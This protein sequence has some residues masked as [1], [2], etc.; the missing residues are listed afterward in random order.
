MSSTVLVTGASGRIGRAL[1]GRLRCESFVSPV[2]IVSPRT[3]PTSD[4]ISVDLRDSRAVE[5]TIRDV[6]PNLVVH[7]AAVVPTQRPSTRVG[8]GVDAISQFSSIAADAGARRVVFAS[9]AAVYGDRYAAPI[10]EDAEVDPRS[11]YA[12]AKLDEEAMLRALEIESVSLRIFNVY[13]AGFDDSLV[14]RLREAR[15]EEPV[16]LFGTGEFVRDYV[17]VS[18]VVDAIVECLT[19]PL[20]EAHTVINVGSGVPTSTR[21]LI[22]CL[23]TAHPLHFREE[24][25][26]RSYSCADI[27]RARSL[28]GF[29]PRG[30]AEAHS[31]GWSPA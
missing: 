19:I 31:Q 27:S 3:S 24:T 17:H 8:S 26:S 4:T 5:T 16:V 14:N 28:F 29:S 7:L 22:E 10:A 13:G 18:D 1:M 15:S 12:Q 23:E 20:P 21:D 30:L 25:G 11:A 2:G 6:Q 9:S